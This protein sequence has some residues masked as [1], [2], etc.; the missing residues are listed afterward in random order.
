MSLKGPADAAKL[1]FYE[2]TAAM[3]KVALGAA[4]SISLARAHRWYSSASRSSLRAFRQ[5]RIAAGFWARG[6]L[7]PIIALL[8]HII[9]SAV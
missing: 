7:L 2:A 8:K 9:G 3:V 5:H 4:A 6:A 1:R